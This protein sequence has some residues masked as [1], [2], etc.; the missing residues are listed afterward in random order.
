MEDVVRRSSVPLIIVL[1]AAGCKREPV[2]PTGPTT[3]P[4]PATV[5][6]TSSATMPAHNVSILIGDKLYD[7]P[8][9][10]LVVKYTDSG[11]SAVLHSIDPP[12]AIQDNYRGNSFY[13]DF[14]D[15]ETPDPKSI[16]GAVFSFKA[17]TTVRRDSVVGIFLNGRQIQ[18]QPQE[19]H[20]ELR[21][22]GAQAL[23]L[24]NGTF[25]PFDNDVANQQSEPVKV[26]ADLQVQLKH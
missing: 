25:L 6:T 1:L 19:L 17:D 11:P 13:F 12:E 2:Q 4:A 8:A 9:G 24:L 10:R 23:V 7:F 22:K 21:E 16:D 15:L 26:Q 3:H 5:P 14:E 18:L 20:V